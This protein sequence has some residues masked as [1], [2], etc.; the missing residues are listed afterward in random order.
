[1]AMRHQA[2][3]IYIPARNYHNTTHKRLRDY[4]IVTYIYA[5]EPTQSQQ[6]VKLVRALLTQLTRVLC[7]LASTGRRAVIGRA[8]TLES[9]AAIAGE[10]AREQADTRSRR[11]VVWLAS[12][13]TVPVDD[14]GV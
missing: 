6:L 3:L 14:L 5:L 12:E 2:A 4:C 13:D 11:R 10:F 7:R 1:M 8:L 9:D